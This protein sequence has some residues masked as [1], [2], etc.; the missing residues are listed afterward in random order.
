M[1]RTKHYLDEMTGHGPFRRQEDAARP[2]ILLISADMVPL[3]F[4]LPAGPHIPLA[5]SRR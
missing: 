5:W 1:N 3:E 4:Y 2:N